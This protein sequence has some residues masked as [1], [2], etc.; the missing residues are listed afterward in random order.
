MAARSIFIWGHSCWKKKCKCTQRKGLREFSKRTWGYINTAAFCSHVF[1][2][3]CTSDDEHCAN[4]QKLNP[5]KYLL[6][7]ASD[8]QDEKDATCDERYRIDI[9]SMNAIAY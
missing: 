2:E 9:Q 5:D 1:Q 8:E 6:I 3:H 7:K 4:D